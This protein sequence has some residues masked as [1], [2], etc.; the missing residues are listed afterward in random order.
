MQFKI[1]ITR[2]LKLQFWGIF[3]KTSSAN[4]YTYSYDYQY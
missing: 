1:Q 3:R 4:F 2:D